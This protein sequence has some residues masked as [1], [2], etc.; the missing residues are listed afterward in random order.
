MVNSFLFVLMDDYFETNLYINYFF[1]LKFIFI[2]VEIYRLRNYEYIAVHN[3]LIVQV[4]LLG[5]MK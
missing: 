4:L 2:L 3:A 1:F 5:G